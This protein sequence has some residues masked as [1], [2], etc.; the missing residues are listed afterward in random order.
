[1]DNYDAQVAVDKANKK[2]KKKK[3]KG[4]SK[5]GLD[6]TSKAPID[7]KGAIKSWFSG[8]NAKDSL[9]KSVQ[10]RKGK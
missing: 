8:D 4:A 7:V 5:I 9:T 10:K 6:W 3:N 1:M 2:K